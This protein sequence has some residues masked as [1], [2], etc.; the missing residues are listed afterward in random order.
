MGWLGLAGMAL[1]TVG[2]LR[3]LRSMDVSYRDDY[4][5]SHIVPPSDSKSCR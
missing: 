2:I 3:W 4:P 1:A 5:A